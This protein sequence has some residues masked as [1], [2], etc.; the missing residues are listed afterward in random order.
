MKEVIQNMKLVIGFLVYETVGILFFL[1]M[2]VWIAI[3]LSL[4]DKNDKVD[5]IFDEIRSAPLSCEEEEYEK[6]FALSIA[7]LLILWPKEVPERLTM[8][9]EYIESRM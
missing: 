4:L 8:L 3:K 7:K 6:L 1:A 2:A 5:E 9:E